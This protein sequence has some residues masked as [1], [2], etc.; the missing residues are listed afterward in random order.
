[1]KVLIILETLRIGGIER[2]AL[3]QACYLKDS[4]NSGIILVLNKTGTLVNANFLDTDKELIAN[5]KIDIR[6]TPPGFIQKISAVTK[7]L[8]TESIDL[9]IDYSLIGTIIA[10]VSSTLLLKR[11]VIN[12]VVQQLAS[13]SSPVQRIK[14]MLY[15]QFASNL[16]MNSV[17]YGID[18]DFYVNSNVLSKML[19]N[20]KYKIIRNGIYLPRLVKRD[21][22]LIDNSIDSLRFIFLGRLKHWKGLSNFEFIDKACDGTANFLVI[23]SENDPKIVKYLKDNFGSRVTFIFGKNLNGYVPQ[24]NDIHIYPVDYGS[25][26]PA[27]ESVSTNCLEMALLGIPSLV[28]AGGTANWLELKAYGFIHEVNWNDEEAIVQ[29]I[30][31]SRGLIVTSELLDRVATATNISNNLYA[32]LEYVGPR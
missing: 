15:A 13:L 18:W 25:N 5:K 9:V 19:F 10:R 24:V 27:I 6:F 23:T 2:N 26:A 22:K 17:N 4:N 29:S 7:I 30:K 3:D 14:R 31:R 16:F 20:K 28:T 21:T 8:R 12:S 11:V 1:M 32:H